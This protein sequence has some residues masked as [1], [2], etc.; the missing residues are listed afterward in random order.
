MLEVRVHGCSRAKLSPEPLQGFDESSSAPR[1][2]ASSFL[3]KGF[4][5]ASSE[6]LRILLAKILELAGVER[7]VTSIALCTIKESGGPPLA[8]PSKEGFKRTH[9]DPAHAKH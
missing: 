3:A 5:K 7:T 1:N 2:T 4:V 9:R 6:S 8:P